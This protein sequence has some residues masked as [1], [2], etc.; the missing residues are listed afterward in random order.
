MP[1][2]VPA[3]RAQWPPMHDLTI[4]PWAQDHRSAD[5]ARRLMF[6]LGTHR[7]WWLRHS[8][9]PLCVSAHTLAAYKTGSAAMPVAGVPYAIDSGAYTEIRDYGTWRW[10]ED[11]YG[12]MVTRLIEVCGPPMWVAPL[13]R[14]CERTVLLRA[15]ASVF[16]HQILTLE[17][18]LYLV[19]EFPYVPWLPVLQGW[20]FEDYIRHD[21]MYR[22]AGVFLG[23]QALVGLGSVCRRGSIRPIGEI[24]K[25]FA[26]RGYRLHGFGLKT[27]ALRA[28]A[29]YFT[30]ADSLAWSEHA[31]RRELRLAGCRHEGPCINCAR[32][33]LTW[34]EGVIAAI[35]DSPMDLPALV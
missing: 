24:A 25:H 29:A 26:E 11:T 4:T 17:S 32:W 10:D 2:H 5:P 23:T 31:R 20:S 27:T 21:A 35:R 3:R 6:L 28:Y 22:E 34:R 16:E 9:V 13:D 19:R 12:S 15:G 30:S 18:Y 1:V 7:P 14:P 8:P 33:A